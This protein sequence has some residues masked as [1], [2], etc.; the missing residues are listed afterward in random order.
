MLHIFLKF[1]YCCMTS[2]SQSNYI[3]CKELVSDICSNSPVLNGRLPFSERSSCPP[4]YS[5]SHPFWDDIGFNIRYLWI[6]QV[7]HAFHKLDVKNLATSNEIR[8]VH[9]SWPPS[10]SWAIDLVNKSNYCFGTSERSAGNE[11]ENQ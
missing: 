9:C 3:N 4:V 8:C 5:I 1:L 11:F 7:Y 6:F 2:G 10:S